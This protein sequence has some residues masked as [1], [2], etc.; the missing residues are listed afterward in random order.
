MKK[1]L[2]ILTY[3]SALLSIAP[4]LRPVDTSAKVILWVPKL[5][6]GALA[7]ILGMISGF[8]ALTGFTR[9]DWKLA[10]VGFLGAGLAAKFLGD[11]PRSEDQFATAFG[12]DWQARV[13]TSLRSSNLPPA[14][15]GPS[16]GVEFQRDVI[17]GY[18]PDIDKDLQADLWQP[19]ARESRTGLGVIYIHGGGW[20]VGDK[21]LGTR[22]FFRRLAG[23]GHVVL[24]VAYT[25]W[26]QADI[27][28][29]VSEV[30]QAILWMKENGEDLGVNPE[31]IILMGGSAG[32]HLALLAAY[33]TDQK[34]FLPEPDP[35]D[36]TVRGVVAFY[37][38]VDLLNLQA[39]IRESTHSHA[40]PV[41]IAVN[42][43]LNWLFMYHPAA[44]EGEG[45][46][47]SDM[48]TEMVG[49][50]PHDIPETYRSLS[51]IYQV[52]PHCP[53]TLLLHGSD[54]VFGLT[55]GVHRLHQ[56]LKAA[57]VPVIL[58]DYPHTDHGFDLVLPQVS[59]IARSAV[60]NIERFL[61]LA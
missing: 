32:G 25:I 8:G 39:Q 10:G 3:L 46:G 17:C 24:D 4:L 38:P 14:L 33:T 52:G 37:P 13:P 36:T 21:D 35:G 53:P 34:T 54:D 61:A 27:Q 1:T 57:G 6:G 18:N 11:I 42:D 5:L 44:G 58:V 59:P 16:D 23:G 2:K 26:P 40:R 55:P 9:R 22:H 49:G 41:D 56:E 30:N 47:M 60:H 15:T 43:M 12:P 19:A 50:S 48:M 51:P 45:S 7:P 28:T 31:R 29:M 20:R